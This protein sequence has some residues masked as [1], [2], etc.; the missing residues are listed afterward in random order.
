MSDPAPDNL[1]FPKEARLR[2]KSDFDLVFSDK[3]TAADHR[4]VVH[5]RPHA[6]AARLGLVVSRKV[7][8]AVTR[9]RWKRL[10]REAF[11]LERHGLPALDLVCIPRP[12][13][14]PDLAELRRSLRE[15]SARIARQWDP[16]A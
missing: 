6:G 3:R 16:T 10:L 11:R 4:L 7:G 9:N 1:R 8:G 5:G 14:R 2:A 13:A 15:L 12:K